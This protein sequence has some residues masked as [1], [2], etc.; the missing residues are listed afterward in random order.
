VIFSA[1][2]LR[3]YTFDNQ[4]TSIKTGKARSQLSTLH[5]K[6]FVIYFSRATQQKVNITKLTEEEGG[7]EKAADLLVQRSEILCYL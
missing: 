7:L 2:D 3:P 5:Y 6:Q 1:L 4:R